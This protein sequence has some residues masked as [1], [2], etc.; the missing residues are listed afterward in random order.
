MWR[1]LLWA[2]VALAALV[3]LIVVG[4]R[5][6]P[7][8]FPPYP[9]SAGTFDYAPLPTD[10]PA[11]V[12]R[13][14]RA[15]YGEEVA[16]RGV[17]VIT[18]AVISGRATLRIGPVTMPGRFRFTHVA[19]EDY[20]HYIETTLFGVPVFKVNETYLDGRG[21]QELPFGVVDNDPRANQAAALGLWAETGWFPAVFATNSRVRWAPVDED[22]ALLTVPYGDGEEVFVVRFDP[23]TGLVRFF[24]AM[25]YREVDR[26][27]KVLWI[28]E[29]V[30]WGEVDGHQTMTLATVA[31]LDQGTPWAVFR[32]EELVLNADV[33][34]YVRA[35][36][37]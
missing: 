36:G 4:L 3:V 11:P 23:E 30:Q 13:F 7:K 1:I 19:G 24:E 37:P 21:R 27:Q 16:S 8:P 5:I 25:R 35:R 17:P 28:T 14:Y 10:L 34:E 26:E 12:L 33:T 9:G 31:W 6:E 29:A 32:T 22:T 18:S 15:V 2:A 20:R